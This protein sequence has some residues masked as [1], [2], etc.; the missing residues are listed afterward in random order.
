MIKFFTAAFFCSLS[1]FV[2]AQSVQPNVPAAQPYG[3]VDMAD[4]QMK[5]CNFEPD[6]N[7]E[8]LFDKA[9]LLSSGG[10]LFQRH[11]RIKIFNDFG[12]GAANIR[13]PYTY[14]PQYG[15]ISDFKGETI[16]LED[17][18]VIVTP[19]D[20]KSANIENVDNW[21]YFLVFSLPNVKVG[22]VIEYQ[23]SMYVINFPVWF[24][25]GEIPT[26]YSE[27][28]TFFPAAWGVMTVPHVKYPF[29]INIGDKDDNR[30][31]KAL[32][33]VPSFKK[34]P[35]SGPVSDNLQR[36]E[37]LHLSKIANSWPNIAN[38]LLKSPVF[39]GQFN[40]ALAGEDE[41]INDAK[42]IKTDEAKTAFIFNLVK[43]RMQWNDVTRCFTKDGTVSAWSKK[44]GNSAEINII[45]Y[46]LLKAVGVRAYPVVVSNKNL[47]RINPDEP[48][49]AHFDNVLVYVPIDTTKKYILDATGKFN[50]YNTI[51]YHYL[52]IYGL[53]LDEYKGEYNFIF[54]SDVDPVSQSVF[55][56]AEIS[57]DGKMTG[58]LER[59]S[60][61]YHKINAL[62][63][64]KTDGE[65]KYIKFL[66]D[67]N[68]NVKLQAVK[69][70][71]METDSLPLTLNAN[72][73]VDLGGVTDGY[74]Y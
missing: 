16:N 25:Q 41:I 40:R 28:Q 61:A 12:K 6:A 10:V 8:V 19:L 33:N 30:Q 62:K 32:S 46:H 58:T 15:D 57:G 18:K 29:A 35:F 68:N 4:L 52:D 38:L 54:L 45:T 74:I 70:K 37:Y 20:K 66:C 5:S 59:T 50:L 21:H 43:N 17:G 51:P 73:N 72:F 34:E 7:A 47:G 39:G 42:K 24:F 22:S 48:I 3:K 64:Y 11:T 44:T 26:R 36:M 9:T 63:K 31:I 2:A 71:D 27:I 55:L 53:S 65:E 56:N 23:Y 13:I 14:Y 69:L 1:L 49:D 67:S 60:Y